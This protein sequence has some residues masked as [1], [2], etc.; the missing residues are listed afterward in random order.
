[1]TYEQ[2]TQLYVCGG[3]DFAASIYTS[4]VV[5]STRDVAIKRALKAVYGGTIEPG[6]WVL[7]SVPRRR[8]LLEGWQ[9]R[10]RYRRAEIEAALD[11]LG[12]S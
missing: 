6:R 10:T 3:L 5:V 7:K 4:A 2:Q 8:Q 1:M 11:S 12:S 9:Q